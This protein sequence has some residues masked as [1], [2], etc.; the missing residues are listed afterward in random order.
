MNERRELIAFHEASHAVI[1]RKLGIGCAVIVLFPGGAGALTS[2][3]SHAAG[4]DVECKLEGLRIDATIALAGPCGNVRFSGRE[5]RFSEGAARDI[6]LAQNNASTIA[7][8]KA[9]YTFDQIWENIA[10][11]NEPAILKEANSIIESI[12]NEAKTLVHENWPTIQ[13]VAK[14]LLTTD[15]MTEEELDQ[16]IANAKVSLLT[17]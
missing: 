10:I 16:L 13:R 12:R 5:K 11:D 14:V 15:V 9:G 2:S 4:E 1:A 17:K 6:D 3:A 8:L 7:V